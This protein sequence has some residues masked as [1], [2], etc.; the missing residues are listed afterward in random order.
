MGAPRLKRYARTYSTA[1]SLYRF[2]AS[3]FWP[4]AST[5]ASSF[6]SAEAK[7]P[8]LSVAMPDWEWS[9]LVMS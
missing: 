8:V 6:I 4:S 2:N 9:A 7:S 5:D 3:A 1:Q